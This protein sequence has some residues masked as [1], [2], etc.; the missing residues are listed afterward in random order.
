MMSSGRRLARTIATM[1]H[2]ADAEEARQ[3]GALNSAAWA[4]RSSLTE[5]VQ[6]NTTPFVSSGHNPERAAKFT[7][8]RRQAVAIQKAIR[9]MQQELKDE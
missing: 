3:L 8:L 7:E 4:L 5:A 9:T 2:A 1:E 6:R